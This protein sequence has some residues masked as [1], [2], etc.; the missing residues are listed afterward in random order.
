MGVRRE[1]RDALAA[2]GPPPA[3]AL[4]PALPV[5]PGG[6][7]AASSTRRRSAPT[8]AVLEIGPGLGALTDALAARARPALPG[9][10]RPRPRGAPRRSATP[11][12]PHVQ[13]VA[14]DV[15]ELP[16]D[17]ADRRA[18]RRRSSRTCR[19][20]SRPRSSSGCSSC[21][22]AF[23]RAVLMLQREVATRLAARPGGK[24]YGVLLGAR[25]DLRAR[26]ASRSACRGGASCR[27]PTST[28]RSSTCAGRA[29]P[30]RRRRRRR[31]RTAR[32]CAPRSASGGRC[33][34]TRSARSPRRGARRGGAARGA[35]RAPA[36]IRR[37]APRR[38][39][40]GGL[41]ASRARARRA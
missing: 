7:R 9:R 41:R 39:R 8:A 16:L 1:A 5:R 14:G 28:R 29:A 3:E 21:A 40:P 19:T 36:S 30:A 4:G 10:D 35:S 34:A 2:A 24:D 18:A 38:S 15:L 12:T 37:H 22:P 11:T 32:S 31:A 13:V 26:C 25:A 27:R 33:C 6:R 23:P 17:D 20:T